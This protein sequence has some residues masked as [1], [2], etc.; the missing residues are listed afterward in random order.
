MLPLNTRH[1]PG[2]HTDSSEVSS[3]QCR[4]GWQCKFHNHY[5]MGKC[6]KCQLYTARTLKLLPPKIALAG[7][8]AID[9]RNL[10]QRRFHGRYRTHGMTLGRMPPRPLCP[11]CETNRYYIIY[12]HP[13]RFH[14]RYRT[15]GMTLGADAS[16]SAV[17]SVR[18]KQI[19]RHLSPR[20]EIPRA[21]SHPWN[22]VGANSS[23]S[24]VPSVRDK[25]ILRHLSPRTEIPRALSHPWNDVGGGCLRIT[26]GNS[27]RRRFGHRW[28]KSRPDDTANAHNS[29]S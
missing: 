6:S 7:D 14:G 15:H 2:S 3:S 22:D 24:A 11:L 19:L 16:A 5:S 4:G 29:A 10:A 8:L 21:L 27:A 1:R 12:R 20:T 18:D 9:G 26:T 25:Q 28:P 17:P 13:R 23:A